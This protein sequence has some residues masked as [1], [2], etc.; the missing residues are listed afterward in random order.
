MQLFRAFLVS[1]GAEL[2]N[3]WMRIMIPILAFGC[4]SSILG[5]DLFYALC[6]AGGAGIITLGYSRTFVIKGQ[7]HLIKQ[8]VPG[9]VASGLVVLAFIFPLN[10]A[11]FVKA[12]LDLISSV[13]MFRGDADP[14]SGYV[15]FRLGF[16]LQEGRNVYAWICYEDATRGI[17]VR[18][19]FPLGLD[20]WPQNPLTPSEGGKVTIGPIGETGFP[21]RFPTDKCALLLWASRS[22]EKPLADERAAEISSQLFEFLQTRGLVEIAEKQ[23]DPVIIEELVQQLEV[24][25]QLVSTEQIIPVFISS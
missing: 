11:P 9:V 23:L 21:F 22:I 24:E 5:L 15:G 25:F 18:P 7:S 1:Y 17:R 20:D 19:V 12:E 10:H 2:L 6:A 4:A 16:S 3:F 13:D 14:S 8:S